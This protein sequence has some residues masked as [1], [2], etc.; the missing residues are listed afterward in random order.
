MTEKKKPTPAYS[1]LMTKGKMG[2]GTTRL[3]LTLDPV[4]GTSKI[5]PDHGFWGG[6]DSSQKAM[7]TAKKKRAEELRLKKK[8]RRERDGK[9]SK[10]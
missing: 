2:D 9:S 6:M 4:A 5:E 7:R 1:P 8:A 10:R 3:R